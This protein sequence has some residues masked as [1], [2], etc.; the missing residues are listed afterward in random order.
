MAAGGG[1]AE[2]ARNLVLVKAG[3]TAL[4][5]EE[6][7][8]QGDVTSFGKATGDIYCVVA[9]VSA[10]SSFLNNPNFTYRNGVVGND[11]PYGLRMSGI[12]VFPYELW[13]SG[14]VQRNSGFPEYTTVL[15]SNG[16]LYGTTHGVAGPDGFFP[17]TVWQIKP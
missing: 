8:C 15:V 10:C 1:V 11:T 14:T 5:G 7:N 9:Y 6:V 12:Y 4:T 17:G 3:C 2:E 13:V 16:K